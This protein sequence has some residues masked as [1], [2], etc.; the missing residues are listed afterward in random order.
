MVKPTPRRGVML[1]DML[2]A[3]IMLGAAVVVLMGMAG[4]AVTAQRSGENLEAAAMILDEQ[5]NL[6]LARGPDQ[7][8][9]RFDDAEGFAE[10]PFEKF[11]YKVDIAA[12]SGGEAYRVTAT[13]W[14]W[15]DGREK[16][17]TVETR[18]A[19]RLGEEPD[20]DRRPPQP[21]DRD[22]VGGAL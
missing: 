16:S 9:S 22:A 3:V 14:W 2:V 6:V 1:V 13:V 4:R 20:P 12:G 15:E 8:T 21:V 17:A 10:A 19:P 7:Y 5:L 18:I 11:R